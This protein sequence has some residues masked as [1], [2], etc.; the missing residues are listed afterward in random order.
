MARP[1]GPPHPTGLTLSVGDDSSLEF[2]RAMENERSRGVRRRQRGMCICI[3]VLLGTCVAAAMAVMHLRTRSPYIAPPSAVSIETSLHRMPDAPS[4]QP[5][6]PAAP[7]KYNHR[8][9]VPTVTV[10]ISLAHLPVLGEA[11]RWRQPSEH[12]LLFNFRNSRVSRSFDTSCYA[13][14]MP[15]PNADEVAYHLTRLAPYVST[16]RSGESIVHH[17]DLFVCDGSAVTEIS[18]QGCLSNRYVGEDGAGPCYAMIWAYDKGATEPHSLPPEMGFRLGAGT[19][20]KSLLLQV[21]YLLPLTAGLTAPALRE[22]GYL[23]TSGV[24]LSLLTELRPTNAWSFE[25]MDRNMAVPTEARGYEYRSVCPPAALTQI[26]EA[27]YA[28]AVNGSITLHHIHAHAHHHAVRVSLHRTRPG[29]PPEEL[30]ALAPYCGYGACQHF[31]AI[32]G[33]PT[34]RKGDGLEFRCLYENHEGTALSY[35]VSTSQEMCGP[36]LIYSPHDSRAPPRT[37]W[38]DGVAGEARRDGG[39]W[40][41][42]QERPINRE[43]F[44]RGR[45]LSSVQQ[46]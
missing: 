21:H 2:D 17:M 31:H 33:E 42:V 14:R 16:T 43:D 20:Y 4:R 23:D 3:V 45:S 1:L 28:V 44:P 25:F 10:N 12:G 30:F 19:P 13:R 26:L 32:P 6:P 24:V 5:P 46:R 18:D 9:H 36:I 34:L 41:R 37:S 15:L 38:H 40:S 7:S 8:V 29:S 22:E 11:Q 35:G 39:P 27:D